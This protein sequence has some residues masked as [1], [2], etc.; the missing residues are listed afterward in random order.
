MIVFRVGLSLIKNK[1]LSTSRNLDRKRVKRRRYRN[2]RVAGN[3]IAIIMLRVYNRRHA[4]GLQHFLGAISRAGS[5]KYGYLHRGTI[6]W[7][8]G[9]IIIIVLYTLGIIINTL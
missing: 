7:L 2:N 3:I 8:E 5:Q 6:I 9:L 1:L 4:Y